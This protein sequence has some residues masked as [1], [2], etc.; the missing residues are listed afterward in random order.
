MLGSVIANQISWRTEI[1]PVPTEECSVG[2]TY[3]AVRKRSFFEM[4]M[5]IRSCIIISYYITHILHF[6]NAAFQDLTLTSA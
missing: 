5:G 2:T 6:K 3:L 4:Q 1:N